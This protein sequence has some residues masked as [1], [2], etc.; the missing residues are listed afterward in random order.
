MQID[1]VD[2]QSLLDGRYK[3]ILN[4]QDHMTKFCN[5]RPLKEKSVSYVAWALYKIFCRW[6]APLILQ[7]DTIADEDENDDGNVLP[8]VEEIQNI[9]D[10]IRKLKEPVLVESPVASS[11]VMPCCHFR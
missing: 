4:A 2:F 8:M 6:R 10:E 1:L 7:S 11:V 3:W 9:R 5:L